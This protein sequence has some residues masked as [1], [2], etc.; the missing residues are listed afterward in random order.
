MV[1]YSC[2]FWYL[3]GTFAKFCQACHEDILLQLVH[4]RF[5]KNPTRP[6]ANRG[7]MAPIREPLCWIYLDI[8]RQSF[9]RSFNLEDIELTV[10]GILRTND[11]GL[12]LKLQLRRPPIPHPFMIAGTGKYPAELLYLQP[13]VVV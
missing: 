3:V 13:L 8:L 1:E 10:F 9:T 7:T 2:D 4:T 6:S 12:E 11:M 5:V